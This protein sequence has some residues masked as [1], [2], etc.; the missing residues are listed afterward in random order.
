MARGLLNPAGSLTLETRPWAGRQEGRREDHF[1]RRLLILYIH[2]VIFLCTHTS[3]LLPYGRTGVDAG[4]RGVDL[5][6]TTLGRAAVAAPL[7]C[8]GGRG[9]APGYGVAWV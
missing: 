7:P 3:C 4:A 5:G 9:A 6:V 1:A 8:A 2:T